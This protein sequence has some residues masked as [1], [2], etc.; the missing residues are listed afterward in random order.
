MSI[1]LVSGASSG[2]SSSS[3]AVGGAP[4]SCGVMAIGNSLMAAGHAAATNDDEPAYAQ[5]GSILSWS[6]L[7]SRGRMRLVSPRTRG[8]APMYDDPSASMGATSAQQIIDDMLPVVVENEPGVC[9][10]GPLG[11]NA[12]ATDDAMFEDWKVEVQTVCATL[13]AAGILPCFIAEFPSG[14]DAIATSRI[15]VARQ[16]AWL[17]RFCGVERIPFADAFSALADP[18]QDAE[19][20]T[21]LSTD[22]L[23]QVSPEGSRVVGEQVALALAPWLEKIP[24]VHLASSGES[25]LLA[26]T[27][28]LS[29]AGA[30]AATIPTGWSAY[31]GTGTVNSNEAADKGNW[32]EVISGG[33]SRI[34]RTSSISATNGDRIMFSFRLRAEVEAF[35]GSGRVMFTPDTGAYVGINVNRDIDE[36]DGAVFSAEYTHDAGSTMYLL[37][38][39]SGD[40]GASVA[41]SQITLANLSSTAVEVG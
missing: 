21:G 28:P 11:T 24:G 26:F 33:S 22:G 40:S 1:T 5:A 13:K 23:H 25:G 41:I 34:I 6:M 8:A 31:S 19:F 35:N 14:V 36:A 9:V 29:I 27:N 30:G 4:A 12:Y 37:I 3:E 10:V 32:L 20:L 17:R 2:G 15:Y 18:A 7:Y 39:A 38:Q 16:N